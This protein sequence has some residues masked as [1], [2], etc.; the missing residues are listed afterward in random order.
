[1]PYYEQL[2]NF[3]Q[4]KFFNICGE[5]GQLSQELPNLLGATSRVVVESLLARERTGARPFNQLKHHSR[6]Y[7]MV[8][9]ELSL[10][11]RE[12]IMHLASVQ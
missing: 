7:T 9:I 11:S 10:Q 8:I 3:E 2:R 5:A 12:S 6:S 4:F 1:M